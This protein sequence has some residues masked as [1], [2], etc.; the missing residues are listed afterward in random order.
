MRSKCARTR[1]FARQTRTRRRAGS[2]TDRQTDGRSVCRSFGQLVG[3]SV[4]LSIGEFV[5]CADRC[6]A[7]PC[8][9]THA[10]MHEGEVVLRSKCARTRVFARQTRTCRRAGSRTD[11]QRDGRSVCR[12]FGQLV[13]QL[14]VLSIGELVG[15]ADRC[16]ANPCT[17]THACMH[18][19]AS[20]RAYGC[21]H[22][23]GHNQNCQAR[24]PNKHGNGIPA[25]QVKGLRAQHTH[26]MVPD[27]RPVWQLV[28]A[29][30]A[31][32][33][34]QPQQRVLSFSGGPESRSMLAYRSIGALFDLAPE[35]QTCYNINHAHQI[36]CTP[37]P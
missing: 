19:H 11:Q 32:A 25:D 21:D 20:T 6:M 8:T 31:H 7:N 23:N 34:L 2:R 9:C 24:C 4:V 30:S 35:R 16:M 15:C 17:C 28:Q 12:S 3:Q 13:G 22:R 26:G 18:T 33:Q 14:V 29:A 36:A 37:L 10:R 5:G 27:P 1:V